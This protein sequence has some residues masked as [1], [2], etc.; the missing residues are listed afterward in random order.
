MQNIS[1][2]LIAADL[3]IYSNSDTHI[4]LNLD[5]SNI[6][7]YFKKTYIIPEIFIKDEIV[8]KDLGM[9]WNET[10]FVKIPKDIHLLGKTW[11]K[12]TIPYFQMIEKLTS[13][14]TTITNNATI[15]QMIF[16][17]HNAYL[18][19]YDDV[20][21]LIPDFFLKLP[22]LNYNEFQ[23][24]FNQVNYIFETSA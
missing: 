13:T 7:T 6:I 22:E 5:T 20:Y 8:L 17:N 1:E 9:K 15:N 21:Y 19:I 23:F 12:V 11:I 10:S 16:D 14:T 4:Y 18:I 2:L 3:Q 24:K